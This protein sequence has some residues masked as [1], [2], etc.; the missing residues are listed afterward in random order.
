MQEKNIQNDLIIKNNE[1]ITKK[2]HNLE[3]LRKMYEIKNKNIKKKLNT[4]YDLDYDL[5]I[6][7][8]KTKIFDSKEIYIPDFL[9]LEEI[10][11][12]VLMTSSCIMILIFINGPVGLAVSV[13]YVIAQKL[14]GSSHNYPMKRFKIIMK[15]RT[16]ALKKDY[17]I[18]KYLKN[19]YDITLDEIN[20]EI[21][22]IDKME[23]YILNYFIR[24]EKDIKALVLKEIEIEDQNIDMDIDIE[25]NKVNKLIKKIKK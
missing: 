9:F 1:E 8:Q 3:K 14:L 22:N 12:N 19:E 5:Y 21:D 4:F 15:Y 10:I 11:K 17:E 13:T 16:K 23:K 20:L 6:L 24:L 2:I 7:N 18:T 25:N